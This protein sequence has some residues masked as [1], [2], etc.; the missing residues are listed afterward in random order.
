MGLRF[1]HKTEIVVRAKTVLDLHQRGLNFVQIAT[2]FG[3]TRERV[4]Q[5]H[6][7]AL[8]LQA[9]GACLTPDCELSIRT[10]NALTRDGIETITPQAVRAH[11]KSL[12]ELKRVPGLGAQC[13][14]ELQEWLR[15]Y[16]VGEIS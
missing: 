12:E 7:I 8:Q 10:N 14:A 6:N 9:I 5:L 16:G 13:I 3:V 4:R 2:K 1:G 11:Y 15:K